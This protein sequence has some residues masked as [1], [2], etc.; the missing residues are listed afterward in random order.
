MMLTEQAK[1]AANL[2]IEKLYHKRSSLAFGLS[3]T[4]KSQLTYT[5]FE[6]INNFCKKDHSTDIFCFTSTPEPHII[7]CNFAVYSFLEA[8]HYNGV[9]I[10][11]D[12]ITVKQSAISRQATI[13]YYMYDPFLFS[14]L[15]QKDLEYMVSR[16]CKLIFRN[17]DYMNLFY[18]KNKNIAL[19]SVGVVNDCQIEDILRITNVH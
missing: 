17:E 1:E 15:D 14:M 10:C 9:L 5:L 8:K 16:E 3:S 11:T 2:S 7:P 12:P 13:F 19:E 6:R 4:T 18:E